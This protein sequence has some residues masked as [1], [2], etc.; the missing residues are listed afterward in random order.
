[1]KDYRWG[2]PTN[3]CSPRPTGGV[4]AGARRANATHKLLLLP[5]GASMTLTALEGPHNDGTHALMP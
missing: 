2:E 1:M 5:N 4:R 3:T